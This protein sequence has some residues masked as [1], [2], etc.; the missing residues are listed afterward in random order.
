MIVL[1]GSLEYYYYYYLNLYSAVSRI[2]H[3]SEHCYNQQVNF[4]V[5]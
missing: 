4:N 2:K 3:E 1:P 5:A